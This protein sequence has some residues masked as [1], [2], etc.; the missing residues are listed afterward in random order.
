MEIK[1]V[2]IFGGIGGCEG[3]DEDTNCG[4]LEHPIV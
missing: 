3:L 2:L 4:E 1:A